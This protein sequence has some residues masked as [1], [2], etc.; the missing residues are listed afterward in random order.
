M[1]TFEWDAKNFN[2]SIILTENSQNKQYSHTQQMCVLVSAFY[3]P[4]ICHSI[5]SCPCMCALCDIGAEIS[6]DIGWWSFQYNCFSLSF[7]HIQTEC[8]WWQWHESNWFSN[9]EVFQSPNMYT[10][11]VFWVW[12]FSNCQYLK[13]CVHAKWTINLCCI[14]SYAM[15][16]KL[17]NQHLS[18]M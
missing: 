9:V 13:Y 16:I 7:P 18:W 1:F 6:V 14:K 2:A 12:E 8:W 5:D 15:Q 3:A 17:G 4:C 11:S 10:F